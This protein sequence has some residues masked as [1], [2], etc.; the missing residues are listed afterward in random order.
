MLQEKPLLQQESLPDILEWQQPPFGNGQ[1]MEQSTISEH[2]EENVSM[3]STNLS[4]QTKKRKANNLFVIAESH[5]T[6]KKRLELF[7]S[8]LTNNHM[9]L[10][11]LFL[12][13]LYQT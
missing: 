3:K 2:L 11:F 12:K 1:T 4:Q 13:D 10:Y 9:F 7:Q 8:W 5:P 6:D